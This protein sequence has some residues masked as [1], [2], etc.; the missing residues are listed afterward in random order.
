M[1]NEWE[2]FLSEMQVAARKNLEARIATGKVIS[3]FR[4]SVLRDIP[5]TNPETGQYTE[6]YA[7]ALQLENKIWSFC[8]NPLKTNIPEDLKEELKEIMLSNKN[9]GE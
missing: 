9:E 1:N 7:K 6:Q 4:T 3:R 8:K 2:I 5:V